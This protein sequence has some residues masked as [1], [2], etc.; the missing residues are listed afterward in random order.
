MQKEKLSV[1]PIASLFLPFPLKYCC[2][3]FGKGSNMNDII[4]LLNLEDE[5]LILE[6]VQVIDNIKYISFSKA[7]Q[8]QYCPLCGVRMHSRGVRIRKVNHP[9]LQDGFSLILLLKQRRW[10]CSNPA[11][12]NEYNEAFRFVDP[13]K[14]NTRFA[15]LMILQELRDL[16]LTVSSIAKRHQVSDSY[17]HTLFDKHVH[18]HRLPLSEVLC[19]D[20]VFLDMDAKSKYALM[21][22]D[23]STGDIID[24]IPSRQ[25]KVTEPYFLSI[26]KKER[27]NVRYLV[28]D[29]YA[30]YFEYVKKFFP[31]AIPVV[32][33]F[34]VIQ[35][36]CRMIDQHLRNLLKKY[37]ARD[38]QRQEEL[39]M[40][41]GHPVKI[42]KSEEVYL[43]QNHR[44]VILANSGNINYN[45]RLHYD[46]HLHRMADTYTYENLF[47]KLSPDLED[48]RNLKDLY[49]DFNQTSFHSKEEAD[50]RLSSLICLYRDSGH[51]IFKEF[52]SLLEKFQEPILNSFTLYPCTRNGETVQ[53]RL[54][55]GLMESMNRKPKDLKRIARGYRNFEHLRNRILF[56][57]RK[58]APILSQP[59]N[60]EEYEVKT[61]K[62]R[63]PYSKKSNN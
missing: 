21:L 10:R 42:P 16:S 38:A 6:Q 54:S 55:N 9:V 15:D 62:I 61:G 52:S 13:G 46:K 53:R 22:L 18:L 32:D 4:H 3:N 48:L 49:V 40:E 26:P 35:W 30:P 36:L 33:S 11:C 39:S 1:R 51:A 17:V 60:P 57:T 58:N 34:H 7:P 24:M 59:R 63:G 29:M 2:V 25:S 50:C 14:R 5:N 8:P 43:L 47:L 31:N 44:W 41:A 27:Q 19:V 37:K 56:G 45:A 23:F 28:A 12:R 20:E